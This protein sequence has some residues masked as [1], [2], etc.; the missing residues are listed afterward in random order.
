[1]KINQKFQFVTGTLD[2]ETDQMICIGHRKY[3]NVSLCIKSNM[4]IPIASIKLYSGNLAK[5]AD[6]TFDDAYAL[7]EEIARRW[8][9]CQTKK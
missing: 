9:E 7:G 5:D 1:M 4:H 3:G 6:L 8:N 2:T